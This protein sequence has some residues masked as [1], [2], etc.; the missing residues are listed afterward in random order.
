M[1]P[2]WK[3]NRALSKRIVVTGELVLETPTHLGNGD[4]DSPLDMSIIRDVVEGKALLTGTSIAGAL[5]NYV[6]D[7]DGDD[8]AALL[9]GH[10]D[11]NNKSSHQSWLIV[12]DALGNIP[13]LE[14]RDNVTIN[15]KTQMA[16][17][18][19]KFDLELL[20]AGTKF[21]IGFELLVPE[22]Q[23]GR[24]I[25]LFVRALSG[26]Q[27]GHIF[28]GKRKRRGF[29]K[30][31]VK[32]WAASQYDVGT[33]AGMVAWLDQ[34]LE[35]GKE[36]SLK[37]AFPEVELTQKFPKY[38]CKLEAKFGVAS[39]ILIGSGT[40]EA[41]AP[42]KVHLRSR[43]GQDKKYIPILSGTSLAGALRSR[44]VRIGNTLGKD[45][46]A[47]A[48]DLFGAHY[49]NED[50]KAF[51]DDAVKAPALT[52]SRIWVEETEIKNP[53]ELIH[54]R[55]KIDRFT[56]GAFSGA[57]FSEQPVFGKDETEVSVKLKVEKACQAD[58]GLI[59]LLLKDLWTGDLPIGGESSVGRGRLKGKHAKLSYS[60]TSWEITQLQEDT[61]DVSVEG[62]GKVEDLQ[63]FVD[64]FI[65]KEENGD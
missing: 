23:E 62:E 36:V 49:L 28:L 22:D 32:K 16:E 18:K 64:A 5:R 34:S 4:A 10:L 45:G 51:K 20:V 9:F 47:L 50:I 44:T 21:D 14:I 60:G 6:C 58:V 55:V 63:C 53:L 35:P 41:D 31:K 30:C 17:D 48:N 25:E 27:Q 38:C 43:R 11:E 19:R 40:G 15:P 26:L 52:A 46:Y 12:E 37:E 59:L 56:G 13:E 33:K 8:A 57:L 39:S 7:Y 61:L 24:I 42:D 29:G 54:T 2:Q 3:A 65:A 1:S